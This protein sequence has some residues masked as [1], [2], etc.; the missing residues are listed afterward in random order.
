[1][2]TLAG[3]QRLIRESRTTIDL[4]AGSEMIA[5][6][7]LEAAAVVAGYSGARLVFPALD[8]AGTGRTGADADT[9]GRT[10]A[11]E[12]PAALDPAQSLNVPNRIVALVPPG[13]GTAVATAVAAA[14]NQ[15][16]DAWMARLYPQQRPPTPGVPSVQWVCLPARAADGQIRDYPE[17]WRLAQQAFN[18]RR[19]VRDFVSVDLPAGRV[20]CSLSPRW[21]AERTA[22][23]GTP[24]YD[25]RSELCA[26]N[27]VKRRWLDLQR[28][29]AGRH[30]TDEDPAV[31]GFPSTSGIAS[32]P[33]RAT[34]LSAMAAE[35]PGGPIR[36]AVRALHTAAEDLRRMLRTAKVQLPCERW[37]CSVLPA[38]L[39]GDRAAGWLNTDAGNWVYQESWDADRLWRDGT[40]GDR[41][42][43][44]PAGLAGVVE[45]GARAAR[46]LAKLAGAPPARYLA[47]IAQDIDSMGDFL[48]GEGRSQGGDLLPVTIDAHT[49]ISRRLS[50]VGERQRQGLCDPAIQ[51]VPV[52]TG[53]DDLLA[54]VPASTALAAAE[55]IHESIAQVPQLPTAS[56]AVVFFHRIASLRLAVT[57]VQELLKQAKHANADK[58]ALGVGFLRRSGVRESTIQPWL[59]AERELVTGRLRVFAATGRRAGLSPRLVA[60]LERDAVELRSL[61]SLDASGT[62]PLVLAL[63]EQEITRLVLRH[64]GTAEDARA[65]LLLM[66]AERARPSSSPGEQRRARAAKVAVFLRQECLPPPEPAEARL[67]LPAG[68]PQPSDSGSVPA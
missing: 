50:A 21:P 33:F 26:T 48:R 63:H 44:A 39:A 24:S 46:A 5:R 54:L 28:R 51:G 68:R 29:S 41:S 10:G 22:P 4:R 38:A 35:P 12:A 53:G 14:V 7:A 49:E 66:R 17:L 30:G 13:A 3:V 47:V 9:V 11:E 61:L 36:C 31:A 25:R 20:P 19:R 15:R 23:A 34:L 65:L 32:A 6:L 58:H 1:M 56:T 37:V 42:Q 55:T 2:L 27:W 67:R 18:A 8:R 16:W 64:H 59:A 60:E 45:A 40:S 43:T 62:P 57:E 52:Y